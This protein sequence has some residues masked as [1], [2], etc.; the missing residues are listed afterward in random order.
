MNGWLSAND[1]RE[2]E[3]MNPIEGGDIYLV[4]LNMQPADTLETGAEDETA[5][6]RNLEQRQLETRA[7]DAA[8]ERSQLAATTEAIIFDSASRII[9]REV[10]D[11]RR[12]INKFVSRGDVQSFSLWL[13]EFYED[14]R[15]FWQRQLRPVLIAYAN[16]V[17]QA[18]GRELELDEASSAEEIGQFIDDYLTSLAARQVGESITQ[19]KAI[20]DDALTAG[21]SPEEPLNERLDSWDETRAERLA[22]DESSQAGNAFA[23]Q[24]Y[25][26]AG[27][28]RLIWVNQG[29]EN[30]PFCRALDGKTVGIQQTF[31]NKGE[32]FQP[33]GAETPINKR[34][35]VGHPPLHKGCDCQIVAKRN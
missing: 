30:C 20:I 22:R 9:R 34:N 24:F 35:N 16:L 26:L 27:V 13:D 10:N 28:T 5:S 12:A 4:P 6:S 31:L 33:E 23:R 3:N 2:F 25:L 1:I 17:A 15:E 32:D 21:E 18:V 7:E 14:H 11:V 8:R 19:L 29:S